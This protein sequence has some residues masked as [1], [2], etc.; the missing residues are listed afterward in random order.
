[1]TVTRYRTTPWVLIVGGLI[2]WIASFQL[3]LDK[4]AVLSDPNY[5]PACDINPVLSCGSVIVTDQA[6]VFGFPN[7]IIGLGG[8]A[9]VIT[10]GVLLASKVQ[11]PRWIWLGLNVG[12]LAGF[13]FVIWLVS[14]SL[15]SIGAL[16]PWCMVVWAVTIV[17]FWIVT[18]E[19]AA[20]AR[21][22]KGDTPGAIADTI[23]ALRWVLIGASYLIVLGL[24]FIRWM[25][26][27]LGNTPI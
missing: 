12:A 11:I 4:I 14:Q 27:W 7:P 23:A 10:I 19:N 2:G 6:S 5:S 22:S 20:S 8:F 24:I 16:C 15:Y 13:G 26:F 17:I 18:A 1:M 25:D 21:F 3:T 9:V